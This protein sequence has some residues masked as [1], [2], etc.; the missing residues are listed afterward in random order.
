M[1][2]IL[3]TVSYVTLAFIISASLAFAAISIVS[4]GGTGVGTLTGIVKGNGTSPFT[5]ATAGTDYEVP[6]TFSTGLTRTTNTVTVNTTQNITRLSN[7]TSNG[8]VK[9]TSA[10]GTLA[11]ATAGTDY[12]STLTGA[13]TSS[14]NATSLGSFT[15]ANLSGALTDETGSGS[16]VFSTLPTLT[17]PIVNNMYFT[18]SGTASEQFYFYG[19]GGATIPVPFFY[20]NTT[21]T[22]LAFD[23]SPNGAPGNTFGIGP[24]WMDILST[25]VNNANYEVLRLSKRDSGNGYI[26]TAQG[27]TGSYRDLV[28]QYDYSL[29]TIA[30]KVGIAVPS[31]TANLDVTPSTTGAAALRIRSGATPTSPNTGDLWFDGTHLQFRNGATTYQIDQQT[32][33]GSGTVTSVATDSTLTGGTITTTGTLGLNLSNPN[34]WTGAQ[35]ISTAP[36]AISGN[37]SA[38]AWTTNGIQLKVAAATLNDTTST[39]TVALTAAD[40][41]FAPTLTATS[42]TTYTASTTLYISGAPTASTNVTQSN[43]YALYVAAGQ[44]SFLGGIASGASNTSSNF[45]ANGGAVTTS[46]ST[47]QSQFGGSTSVNFRSLF[48]GTTN[49]VIGV[50]FNYGNVIVASDPINTAATGTNAWLANLVVNPIGT[51][52]GTTTATNSA[53]LYIGGAASGATNNYSLFVNSG[54]TSLGGTLAV[55]GHLTLEGVT[56]TGA[57][58]TG[59]LVFG[60]SPTFTTQITSPIVIGSTVANGTL[61]FK[62]NTAS[63][64]NTAGNANLV[65]NVGNSAAL[66]AM[67]IANNGNIGMGTLLPKYNLHV[68][69]VG[70][71]WAFGGMF[72][73]PADSS[74]GANYNTMGGNGGLG[75]EFYGTALNDS[76]ETA[77]IDLG[78]NSTINLRVGSGSVASTSVELLDSNGANLI[79]GFKQPIVK[80][81]ATSNTLT[82]A[83][84]TILCDATSGNQTDTLPT[85]ATS[86]VTSVGL[87]INFQKID[88][89]ANT[90]T[91][92]GNGT[93]LVGAG[94]TNTRVI[95]TQGTTDIE[96]SNGTQWYN[97]Q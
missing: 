19:K 41:I 12:L 9:T 59:A 71:A 53:S 91:L 16:A 51:I 93:E 43:N 40:S 29:S 68:Q 83:Q 21:N 89:S 77:R 26:T 20:P 96:Q 95:S 66:S 97:L 23:L 30:G 46:T 90:C 14:G 32:G 84:T 58:G 87:V 78:S 94:G 17:T 11:T 6:L 62:G 3:R 10:N 5:A 39:G 67:V 69:S 28:L 48:N 81:T 8:L 31:P 45:Y 70:D 4:N 35:T 76:N 60:T 24:T 74:S 15:S 65:F 86:F 2:N 36:F 75:F 27:G 49:S 63:T 34:T 22:A 38:S 80:L 33:G 37:Q 61:T 79:G 42:A 44:S 57:T 18:P 64:A 54:A 82:I 13:V 47:A 88:S 85:A 55:T 50:G 73:A 1:K 56:S 25:D 52:A 92:K 72:L 7:L